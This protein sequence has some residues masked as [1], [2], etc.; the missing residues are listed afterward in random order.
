M[1]EIL[2]AIP[3]VASITVILWE[4]YL[5]NRGNFQDAFLM[6]QILLIIGNLILFIK[7]RIN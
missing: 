4:I 6:V 5:E 7:T 3:M 1:P 2:I